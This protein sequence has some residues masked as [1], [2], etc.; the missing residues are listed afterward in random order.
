MTQQAQTS[1]RAGR[2]KRI[3]KI[4]LYSIAGLVGA[5]IALLIFLDTSV[6]HRFIVSQVEGQKF[7][8]GMRLE[9]KELDGSIYGELE[10]VGLA[11]HDPT[12]AFAS[13]P[14]ATIDWSPFKLLW[15]HLDIGRLIA[16]EIHWNRMPEFLETSP[17]DDPLLPDMDIDIDTLKFDRVVIGEAVAG[18][19]YVAALTSEIHITNGR[20]EMNIDGGA[21]SSNNSA[22]VDQLTAIV[23]AMPS[24]NTLDLELDLQ[25][26]RNGLLS[27]L[28]GAK[29]GI[30]ASVAG[31]GDW[32]KWVGEIAA[33]T[34]ATELAKFNLTARDGNFKIEG[35]ASPAPLLS[36][37]PA[38]LLAEPVTLNLDVQLDE[39]VAVLE[40]DFASTIFDIN[41]EGSVDFGEN[42]FDNLQ[43]S[44]AL[45]QP[46][47][48]ADNISVDKLAGSV[49]FD[50]PFAA[51]VAEYNASA[52][53]LAIGNTRLHGFSASGAA[54]ANE[55]HFSIPLEIG[56]DSLSGLDPE[57]NRQLSRLSIVGD[58]LISGNRLMANDIVIDSAGIA[59]KAT[60]LGDLS[61][62]TYSAKLNGEIAG[63]EVA[64]LGRFDA[65]AF[66]DI[67]VDE[68]GVSLSGRTITKSRRINSAG[69]ESIL[70]GAALT[71]ADIEYDQGGNFRFS[72]L[73]MSAPKFRV[74]S[75]RGFYANNGQLE[76]T[77]SALSSDY[78]PLEI[79]AS[80]I[81][82]ALKV[83][84]NAEQPGLGLGI[85]DLVA[86]IEGDEG[87]YFVL[88]QGQSPY[89][90]VS[91]KLLVDTTKPSLTI[92]VQNGQLA[93]V[94]MAGLIE[95]SQNGAFTGL[96]KAS[97][98]GVDG[99]VRLAELG[100]KQR[101]MIS[102]T[103]TSARFPGSASL[104]IQRAIIEADMVLE[105]RPNITADIQLAGVS[106][107]QLELGRGRG[108][109]R[110]QGASG[111]AQF[112][113]EGRSGVDFEVAG[114]A[115]LT[116]DRWLVRVSGNSQGNEFRSVGNIT[117]IPVA[118][119]YVINPSRMAVAG[120]AM[121]FSGRFGESTNVSAA[122]DS[123][124]LSILAPLYPSLGLDGSASGIVRWQQASSSAFPSANI[125]ITASNFSRASASG[126][127]SPVVLVVKG[128]LDRDRSEVK[129]NV[130][131]QGVSFGRLQAVVA[132]TRDLNKAWNERLEAGAITGGLRYNGPA[133]LL[134]S[135]AALPEQRMAGGVAVAA[136][137][138]GLA[139]EPKLEGLVR[140]KNLSYV[141]DGFG[142]RLS[143]MRIRG[144]FRGDELRI[145]ELTAKA[146][147]GSV[148][149]KGLISLNSAKGYP[150]QLDLAFDD[151][152]LADSSEIGATAEGSLSISASQSTASLIR[153]T[154]QLPETRYQI[155][156]AATVAV[157]QL[158]GVR[159][160][161][162]SATQ[163]A[164]ADLPPIEGLPSGWQLDIGLVADDKLYVSGLGLDSEW[165]ANLKITGTPEAPQMSGTVSLIRGTLGF[166]G[167]SFEITQGKIGFGGRSPLDS[168]LS[169]RATSVIDGVTVIVNVT[170]TGNKPDIRFTS[171]PGLPQDEVLARILFGSS[172]GELS[173]IQAIQLASSLNGLRNGS[174]GV[175]PLGVVQSAVGIDRLRIVS[176]SQNEGETGVA[177]GQYISRDVYVEIVTDAR[178][179]TASQIEIS[180]TPALSVFS[181]IS[182]QGNSNV[183]VKFRK[184]Y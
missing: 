112:F 86:N 142:T 153:G 89:G 64:S 157:P 68:G 183:N 52:N 167:R 172:V 181:Q 27:S 83:Q 118:N 151:A 182:A 102:A 170:G 119:G 8:N 6:G 114:S 5:A 133:N 126:V 24:T 147:S 54:E 103:A 134:F 141:H 30:A 51:L 29:S 11:V 71:S 65:Q 174:A 168:E 76:A 115:Q 48:L 96:L 156:N 164:G 176:P 36:G 79:G 116:P 66:T 35:I 135:L 45:H 98:N 128:K 92:D 130:L 58:L 50:G 80:G 100:G 136:D 84:I 129:A 131:R 160:R 145:T 70:G 106:I 159:R 33:Q 180:L 56:V 1:V 43:A 72:N 143:E 53:S 171:N 49:R 152:Q 165:K 121:S 17:S 132:P 42:A 177:F 3:G 62:G 91:G 39:S 140:S 16:E 113:A 73:R 47:V 179:Q 40:G 178:G 32:E 109:L 104:S 154:L 161:S 108:K 61:K 14:N 117:V 166:A 95:Q 9:I 146:G 155:S 55:D 63:Y 101:A 38:R 127:S 59:A 99:T 23:D 82:D 94:S 173:P 67:S 37:F 150:L 78:G 162:S 13:A 137:F 15:S 4:A 93:G 60:V 2:S 87:R 107:N 81:A 139:S 105:D 7:E 111:E 149:G 34:G 21:Q 158:S 18:E 184:D 44:F 90:I 77:A 175:N 69:V 148:S 25:S 110:Y 12:G 31:T 122:L 124:D 75:G 138:S 22:L 74:S 169:L 97:G 57:T 10:I 88:A 46:K 123:V 26:P 41:A 20:V 120:G 163:V 28:I 144:S 125:Q 85:T 19:E